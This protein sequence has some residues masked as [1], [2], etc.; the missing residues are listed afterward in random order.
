MPREV[1]VTPAEVA[2]AKKIVERDS[3]KGR[4]T[5]EVI[6][7]IAEVTAERAVTVRSPESEGDTGNKLI[8]PHREGVSGNRLIGWLGRFSEKG[9]PAS[10]SRESASAQPDNRLVDLIRRRWG[11]MEAA[12]DYIRRFAYDPWDADSK[13]RW[14]KEYIDTQR[15]PDQ[16]RRRA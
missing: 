10:Q 2:A 14:V 8:P 3:A 16:H 1:R 7:K 15:E 12:P 11:S 5:P 13:Y 6:R 9:D 4:T